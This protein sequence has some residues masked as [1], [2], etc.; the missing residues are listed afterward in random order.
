M[1]PDTVMPRRPESHLAGDGAERNEKEME[2]YR[3]LKTPRSPLVVRAKDFHEYLLSRRRSV[4]RSD[5]GRRG[6]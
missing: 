2:L 6:C 5:R 3:R 4:R 1:L